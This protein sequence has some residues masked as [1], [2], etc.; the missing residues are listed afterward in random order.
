MALPAQE[1]WRTY[2][3]RSD[4]ENRIKELKYDFAADSFCLNN[5]FATEA[6]LNTVM[7][8]Y[9]L[10]SLF[11]QAALKSSV[12]ESGGKDVQRTLQ[13][14]RYKLFAKAGYITTEGRK[15]VLKLAIAMRQREWFEGLWNQSKNFDLPVKFSPIFSP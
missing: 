2:R 4:C 12:I 13:T 3:G 14:L 1:V 8:A 9:N 11:R 5:F 10:M 15:N 7:M 6:C